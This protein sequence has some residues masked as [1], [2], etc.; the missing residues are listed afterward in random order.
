MGQPVVHFELHGTDGE[1]L[2]KFY[3]DVFGWKTTLHEP[4]GYRIVDTDSGGTGIAGGI[5]PMPEG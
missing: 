2:S 3:G 4:I 5:M 1:A